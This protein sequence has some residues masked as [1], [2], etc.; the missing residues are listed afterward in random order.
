MQA[1]E[2]ILAR[3]VVLPGKLVDGG[4]GVGVVGRKLRVDQI[5]YAEQLFRTGDIGDV[6]I[7]L[8]GIDRVALKPLN[9]GA[10][11]FAVPVGAFHQTNHQAATAAGG[12]IGQV[13]N[14]KRAALHIG[15]DH[16]ADAV[17][18]RQIRIEA[19]FFQ[20]IERDLQP[21]RLFGVDVDPDIV[22]ARQ[23]G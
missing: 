9:L 3:I 17:P 8:A 20:Q 21:V 10:F 19:E 16:E 12:E 23:Q 2:L 4:Q 7:D 15:L 18:A 5:R 6:G 14:D 1:L 22:L 13:V 11:D